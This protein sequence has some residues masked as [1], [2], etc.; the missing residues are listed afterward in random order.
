VGGGGG[1]M[2]RVGERT[3]GGGG[4][5]GMWRSHGMWMRESCHTYE[6]VISHVCVQFCGR[7]MLALA[8]GRAET[9][10]QTHA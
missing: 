4:G 10:T 5:V 8:R 7:E 3:R 2:L 1:D 9:Q 6:G